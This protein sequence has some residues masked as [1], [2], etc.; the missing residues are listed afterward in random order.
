[1]KKKQQT[2]PSGAQC[3]EKRQSTQMET[4]QVPCEHQETLSLPLRWMSKSCQLVH[5]LG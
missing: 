3:Q 4:Q 2:A 5:G 1:M